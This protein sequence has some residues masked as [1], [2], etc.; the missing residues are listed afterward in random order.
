MTKMRKMATRRGIL[1]LAGMILTVLLLAPASAGSGEDGSTGRPNILWITC[2]DMSPHIGCYGDTYA[3]T[4][5]ID[6]L[7]SESV[8]YTRAFATAPV[9]SPVRSCLITG[10]YASSL[11]TQN[12]RS[13]FPIPSSMRGFPSYLRQ[14]G[15]FCTNNVK[16]DYNTR[17]EPEIIRASWDRNSSR[18]HWRDRKPG[19]PFF[20]VFNDMTT[21]QSRTM[22]WPYRQFQEE[23]QVRLKPEEQHDPARA[24][25]PPYYPD[26]PVVRRTVARYYDCIS[27]MDKN[28]KKL[29]VELEEDGLAD[30]TIVFFYS[31]HGS[32]MPRHKRLL[33]DSGMRVPL[34]IRFP[35][36]YRHLAPAAPG[37]T[38]DRLVSFVDFPPTVLSLAGLPVPEYMQGRPFLGPGAAGVEPR[39][40]VYGHRD[41]V[42]EAYDLARSIRDDR[43]LYIR[44][45]MPHLSYNQPSFYSDQGEIRREITRLAG[46]GKLSGAQLHYAGPTRRLEEFYDS[47]KDPYQ[48]HNLASSPDQG[49]LLRKMRLLLQKHISETRD[50]GFLP[51]GEMARRSEGSTPLEMARSSKKY[52]L[53]RIR[54][55]ADLVGRGAGILPEQ[56]R[57]LGDPDAAVR[58]WAA[59]G[60]KVLGEEARP[61]AGALARAL[62]DPAPCVRV[63]AA[64]ALCRLDLAGR[65]LPV[66]EGDLQGPDLRA[67]LRAARALQLLGEKARPALPAMKKVLQDARGRPGDPCMFLRFSLEAAVKNLE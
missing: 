6:R 33:L 31:D 19:Q 50:L 3:R 54:K 51:E 58:Y 37:E 35:E 62:A 5:A 20:S 10:V 7:A 12:L 55:A 42:D 59:V 66:L 29:L 32:G 40:Y 17:N 21:H 15:Y 9:C 67:A 14:A 28:V 13:R 46:E 36:K 24:P 16:T 63:E 30:D 43:Y 41:R 2:E 49:P 48:I 52:P 23:I 1:L 45:Y 53:G 22:V 65:A 27:V 4:P 44:T 25:I 56:V 57:L 61:G 39:R 18:A 38:V 8:R 34:L 47:E 60:L 64:E 26:T 11:G